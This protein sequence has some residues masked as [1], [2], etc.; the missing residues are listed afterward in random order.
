[1]DVVYNHHGRSADSNFDLIV[2]GY[3]FRMNANGS[4][5]NGSGTGNETASEHY[6]MRKFMVDSVAF[7]ADEYQI[8]GFRFDLMKLHDVDT[9]NAIVDKVHEIDEDILIFGEPWT[10][11][12]SPLPESESA[13]NGTLSQM[14]GVAVFNDDTRDAIKGSVFDATTG[15]FIQGN[16]N[17]DE[18]IKLGIVG[19]TEHFGLTMPLLPKGAWADNPNQT[20]N[21]A[22]AHDN[23]VLFDKIKMSTDDATP[24]DIQNMH[25]QAGS[26]LLT[27]NGIPFLHAGIEF[28][29]SKPCT[30]IG[31]EAQGEC[32]ASMLY[33]HNSYRSPDQT[34]QIDWN[35]KVTNYEVFEYYKGLIELRKSV[36]VF[37]MDTQ[38]EI[39]TKIFFF[40]DDKGVVSYL[41][42]DEDSPFEYTYVIHNNA[43]T[44]R[45]MSLQGYEWNLIVNQDQA[46]IETIEVLSGNTVTVRPNETLVM[47]VANG[48]VDWI[49][50][51]EEGQQLI[52]GMC[53]GEAPLVCEDGYHIEDDTCVED[54]PVCE[55]G[56]E[57]NTSTNTCVEIDDTLVCDE[58]FELNESEDE[59][60]AVEEPLV[61]EAGFVLNQAGD[62][63]VAAV[64]D[65]NFD[66]TGCFGS[67]GT[68]SS[69]IA[70]VAVLGGAT[71][72]FVR[73]K[74]L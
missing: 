7:W 32:D 37:S 3:Y 17:S 73:R 50:S 70:I 8:S 58:G 61:C 67:I 40:P 68:G 25:K 65:K 2:P 10:G 26:I 54:V 36:G 60:I 6:M 29:R 56:F 35:W 34:N 23:N 27:S 5:S 19:A 55:A 11:G 63:C 47:Y 43:T 62:E 45:N 57:L 9:M 46:G 33:D 20:I 72:Y 28:L 74:G 31:G 24:S 51:C 30:V 15:G 71:L 53:F 69:V 66:N 38:L 22:T 14:P 49:T 21:Y 41:I 18:T 42:Y 16:Q 44:Q 13:Y 12:S 64:T 59:C 39:A 1:M 52:E 4:F 48:N